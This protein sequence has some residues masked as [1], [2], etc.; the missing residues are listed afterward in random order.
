[1]SKYPLSLLCSYSFRRDVETVDRPPGEA[2]RVGS[3]VHG[4]MEAHVTGRKVEKQDVDPDELAKALRIFNGP[5]KEWLDSRK[6]DVC[7]VGLRYDAET[8]TAV[9]GPRRGDPGYD[10]HGPMVMKGT[11]DLGRIEGDTGWTPDLKTGS[12]SNA[13]VEQVIAQGVAFARRYGLRRVFVGFVFA[14]VR[15]CDEPEW[16]ELDAD[17]IDYE[18]GRIRKHL[19]MLPESKP[20]TGD[21]CWRCDLG[22]AKCP[23]W[24]LTV[25]RDLEEAW[26]DAER[27]AS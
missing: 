18:A 19:R 11:L 3:L 15:S 23:A 6:W 22:K 2:A 20:V 21:H 9:E 10:D 8:D 4:L 17:R 13:H 25:P 24:E 27:A 12:K 1:M 26:S 5:L 14:K 7:E 16:L